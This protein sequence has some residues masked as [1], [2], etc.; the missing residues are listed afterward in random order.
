[1]LSNILLQS[2]TRI[3]FRTVNNNNTIYR[4]PKW[5]ITKNTSNNKLVLLNII[6]NGY[7]YNNYRGLADE[8]TNKKP[9]TTPPKTKPKRE[10]ISV[11]FVAANGEKQTVKGCI[12]DSIL[13]VAHD[14]DIE[15]E[16]ACGGEMACSTCTYTSFFLGQS[17]ISKKTI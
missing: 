1:M 11:T 10:M 13:D 2:R 3:L 9:T 14:N 17:T 12:D 7:H 15:I 16:G 5:L 6:N 4:D 8:A